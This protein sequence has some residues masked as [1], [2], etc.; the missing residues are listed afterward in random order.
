MTGNRF[1]EL[2][3]ARDQTEK[4]LRVIAEIG[5]GLDL[6]ATLHRI[7]SAARELTS[8]PYGAL[9]VRDRHANLISF[10]HEGM[11]AETVRRIGHH[12]VGKGLLSLS[13][14]DT[15]A[16]RMDD[17]TAHPAAA[18]FPEHH[19]AMRAFLAVPITIRG[20]VF[21]NLYLTHVDE[22]RVFSDADEM[23]ARALAFAAAVA[24][25][26][27]QVFER[28]RMSVKWI[29]ASREIT[30]ALLSRTEPHRRPMQL[31]AERACALTDAEQAI[32]LVPADPEQPGNPEVDTL[33]VSAAVG[34]PAADVLGQ[35]VPVRGS[36]SG[37]VFKSGEP[38]IT[39]EFRYPIQAF[40]DAGRRPAIVMPLRARDEVVGVIAIARGTEQPPFDESYLDLVRDFATHAA[41]AL[42]LAAARE[43]ARQLAVLAE[44]ERIAHDLHDHVI[45]RLFAAGMDLQGTLAR[46]RSPEVADRLN[47]T[48]DDLQTIIEEIRTTIFA[49]RS[50][51][52]VA[53]DFRHRIQRV[54][55]ELT[56]NRDLVTTVRM[57][58]PMTAVGAELAEHAEAVTAEAVSNAVRHSGASRLTVQIGVAD[59]FTLDV[60]DNGRGI[61]SGNTRRS[62]LANMTRRA[63]QLGGSCEISSPPG[64]GTRV[65]WTAPL[66]DH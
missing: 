21:G 54:I 14:L 29:E 33:V 15:P 4:L 12:P 64:G 2:A 61:A 65:H 27:A 35:R 5:A 57:D 1:D 6:D 36:T 10:V 32:V 42:V 44:R 39:D 52:A 55:A 23:A 60:I 62:G 26:N 19:P 17:L 18:G 16:L 66:L 58:G 34:L 59:M 63:E 48:L 43:D 40:T 28:E 8:A 13:L 45:Q 20:A 22:A 3:A 51:A 31:I 50:P 53:G 30:T 38:L 47:R 46:A 37:A 41:I 11:D 25:D 56:E 49:L 24:I 9:A 7:I